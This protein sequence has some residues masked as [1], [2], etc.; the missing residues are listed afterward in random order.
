MSEQELENLGKRVFP[1]D[2]IPASGGAAYR[3]ILE[4]DKKYG[5][6]FVKKY[7]DKYLQRYHGWLM[8]QT[9]HEQELKDSM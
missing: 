5:T 4:M 6:E 8:E 3:H 2:K 9:A 1:E 7:G